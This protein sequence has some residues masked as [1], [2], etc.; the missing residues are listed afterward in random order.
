MILVRNSEKSARAH[1]YIYI[2]L[3]GSQ[4]K[5]DRLL[6]EGRVRDGRQIAGYTDI[7]RL[8]FS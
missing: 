3:L 7:Y 4:I 2:Y 5:W 1:T 6:N 8:A